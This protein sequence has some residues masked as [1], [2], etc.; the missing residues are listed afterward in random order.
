MTV[1]SVKY[2]V[3]DVATMKEIDLVKVVKMDGCEGGEKKR[4]IEEGRRR[5]RRNQN[6][7][8]WAAARKQWGGWGERATVP[9]ATRILPHAGTRLL[10]QKQ[11]WAS[12]PVTG[13]LPGDESQG[14]ASLTYPRRS[15]LVSSGLVSS[16]GCP[17]PSLLFHVPV[18]FACSAA[19]FLACL[20]GC[21]RSRHWTSDHRT[22]SRQF[23]LQDDA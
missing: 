16:Q 11:H 19:R 12:Q 2:V 9:A 14:L 8:G 3:M 13:S 21:P 5:R 17:P 23:E 15:R 22:N 4:E 6:N 20:S 1:I 18:T 10:P 7:L